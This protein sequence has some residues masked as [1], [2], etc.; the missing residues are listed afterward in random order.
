MFHTITSFFSSFFNCFGA[1]FEAAAA[2]NLEGTTVAVVFVGVSVLVVEAVEA[3][4]AL[5][6]AV[7]TGVAAVAAGGEEEEEEEEE[8]EAEGTV[9]V[10]CW[11]T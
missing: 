7:E 1:G 5:E 4:E 8:E 3:V 11:G 2:A 9:C 10:A 6:A